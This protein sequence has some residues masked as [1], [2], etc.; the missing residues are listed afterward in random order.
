MSTQGHLVL[1]D[2]FSSEEIELEPDLNGPITLSNGR[3][4]WWNSRLR[5]VEGMSDV[6]V[7]DIEK[8]EKSAVARAKVA[9]LDADGAHIV[10]EQQ[11]PDHGSEIVLFNQDT[12]QQKVI[13]TPAETLA[14]NRNAQIAGGMIAW[15]TYIPKTN[16]SAIVLYN[17]A[18][19][20][21]SE[22]RSSHGHIR[23]SLSGEYLVYCQNKDIHLYAIASGD[24]RTIA[25]LERLK[26][27][28]RI[29]G[30][31][32]VWCEHIRKEEFKGIPGQPL[33]DEKD[34]C[35]VLEYDISSGKKRTIAANLLSNAGV[36]ILGGRIYL[37]VYREYP[38]PGAS[39]LVVSVD[40]MAWQT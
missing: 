12:G 1:L 34:I 26:G 23:Y 25:S 36:N 33:M 13:N 40:L 35:N 21:L 37:P 3:V 16:Q 18:D 39:N 20:K 17:L 6:L 27:T 15:E 9:G 19:Q 10:W 11:H 2:T 8:R 31:R 30:N 24:D 14:I 32:I 29:E 4:I 5:D 38:P 22:I 28:P 7:Y